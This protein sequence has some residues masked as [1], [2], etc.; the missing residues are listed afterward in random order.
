MAAEKPRRKLEESIK[1]AVAFV[2]NGNPLRKVA[3]LYNVTMYK[4]VGGGIGIVYGREGELETA[5]RKKRVTIELA[6]RVSVKNGNLREFT[7]ERYPDT[8][9]YI[10]TARAVD[11]TR[12]ARSRSPNKVFRE[13]ES[14][15]GIMLTLLCSFKFGRA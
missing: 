7:E 3:R 4:M 5:W 15:G 9:I 14:C 13:R 11:T 2:Q 8:R 6:S 12:W 10:L 1:E